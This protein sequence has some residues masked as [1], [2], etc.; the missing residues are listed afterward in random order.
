M[1][2]EVMS[3]VY[4]IKN[5]VNNKVYVGSSVDI[6]TRFGNHKSELNRGKHHNKRL[7]ASYVKYGGAS[8]KFEPVELCEIEQLA[9]REKYWMDKFESI[10]NGYNIAIDTECP[11][12][13][14]PK[15]KESIYKRLLKV[16][17][18]RRFVSPAGVI[19]ETNNTK[20]F[21]KEYNLNYNTLTKVAGGSANSV[22]GWRRA[23]PETIGVNYTFGCSVDT[24]KKMSKARVG[25]KHTVEAR[26]K[27][28]EA[29]R[30][31]KYSQ[32]TL[33]KM[34]LANLG[35]RLSEYSKEKIAKSL[36]GRKCTVETRMKISKSNMKPM[37]A[38]RKA[39]I[40]MAL[41]HYHNSNKPTTI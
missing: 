28:S 40:S 2:R 32:E 35:K 15:S 4:I 16:R 17:K 27:I 24:R 6:L 37:T 10:K 20:E 22:K 33:K 29:N 14:L 8:F 39:N 41:L 34:S 3:G 26:R 7:L 9:E 5:I 13:G 30:C 19:F 36:T 21:A 1:A 18:N 25:K 31:R 38:A 11:F 12:R 23:T